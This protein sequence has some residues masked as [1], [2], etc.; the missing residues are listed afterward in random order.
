VGIGQD[1]ILQSDFLQNAKDI[2]SKLDASADLAEFRSLFENPDRK[3]TMGKCV[4][5]NEPADASARNKKW[6]GAAIRTS[7]GYNLTSLG[8]TGQDHKT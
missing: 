1:G 3:P 4:G 5:C 7:L 8:T 6:G 2:G